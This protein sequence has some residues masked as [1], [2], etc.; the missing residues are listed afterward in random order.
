MVIVV[1]FVFFALGGLKLGIEFRGGST[2]DIQ[3]TG[4]DVSQQDLSLALDNLGYQDAIVQRLGG[5]GEGE[6]FIRTRAITSTDEK[7]AL[8]DGLRTELGLEGDQLKELSFDSV[9]ALVAR[10][11]IRNAAIAVAVGWLAILVYVAIAFRNMPHPFVYSAAAIIAL[12]HDVLIAVGVF[13]ILGKL[14]DWEVNSMLIVAILAI[15]GFSIN[16]TIVVYDR[17]REHL[18]QG[19]HAN[20]HEV[21]NAAMTQTMTRSLNTSITVLIANV[22]VYLFIGAEIR[23]FSVAMLVGVVSGTYSSIFIASHLVVV[24]EDGKWR[25]YVPNLPGLRGLRTKTA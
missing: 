19:K 10:E 17:I 3:I 11:T 16:D 24:W 8:E 20:F 18:K 4:K 1:G 2:L 7:Q 23:D 5:G 9:T 13:A 12:I 6:F 21:V 25:K 14:L 15:I 22:A